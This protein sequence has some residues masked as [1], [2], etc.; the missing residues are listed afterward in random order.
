MQLND[1]KSINPTLFSQLT[2]ADQ[3]IVVASGD[4]DRSALTAVHEVET[5]LHSLVKHTIAV[6]VFEVT[7]PVGITERIVSAETFDPSN[8]TSSTYYLNNC[9]ICCMD[10]ERLKEQQTDSQA[11]VPAANE[12]D[13]LED[14]KQGVKS[15]PA[16]EKG[17]FKMQGTT[18]RENRLL[19]RQEVPVKPRAK[20][21]VFKTEDMV[22]KL[23]EV[24]AE[25]KEMPNSRAE[26]SALLN[27]QLDLTRDPLTEQQIKRRLRYDKQ[28]GVLRA[29]ARDHEVHLES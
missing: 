9:R 6:T 20:G 5:H 19:S 23:H 12:I 10:C 24:D 8:I 4:S 26:R 27:A 28:R 15:E 18:S 13:T 29:A 16:W 7:D 3:L 1:Q 25:T 2:C 11:S 22:E 14:D 17:D 21:L